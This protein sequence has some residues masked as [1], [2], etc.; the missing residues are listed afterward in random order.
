MT[1]DLFLSGGGGVAPFSPLDLGCNLWLDATDATTI[2]EVSGDVSQWD[3]KSGNGNDVT[4]TLSTDRP[5][6]GGTLNGNNVIDWGSA[7][8]RKRLILNRGAN[9]DNWQDVYVV[10]KWDAADTTFP[11]FNGLFSAFGSTGTASGI[12]LT[13]SPGTAYFF[14]GGVFY[15][16]LFLNSLSISVNQDVLGVSNTI[17]NAFYLSFSANSAI[18]VDGISVGGERNNNSN[19]WQGVIGEVVAFPTKLNATDRA[20]MN[21]YLT[22]KWG[23]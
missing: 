15:D 4:Q 13:G 10:G 19:G 21:T 17:A 7:T 11:R 14:S 12:G 16:N 5:S 20:T 22:N 18:G 2:T 23:L 1:T 3:D 8:N 9:T 6:N